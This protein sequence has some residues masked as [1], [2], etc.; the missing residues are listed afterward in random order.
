LYTHLQ[1]HIIEIYKVPIHSLKFKATYFTNYVCTIYFLEIEGM[2]SRQTPSKESQQQNSRK[3]YSSRKSETSFVDPD[4]ENDVQPGR[5]SIHTVVLEI[6]NECDL[7]GVSSDCPLHE[8]LPERAVHRVLDQ[9]LGLAR[10]LCHSDT[11]E[12]VNPTLQ[13][14]SVLDRSCGP[15]DG[16]RLLHVP[17]ETRSHN[18]C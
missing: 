13:Q 6:F 16:A 7:E 15:R 2:T 5:I 14:E 8:S 18:P 11:R 3:V 9:S 4:S 10:I 12:S 17:V 1:E